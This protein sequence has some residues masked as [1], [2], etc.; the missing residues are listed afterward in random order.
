MW[1][2]IK[3]NDEIRIGNRWCCVVCC[4]VKFAKGTME[5]NSG[6]AEIYLPVAQLDSA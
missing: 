4:A 2:N 3:A 1:Y 5:G 6:A